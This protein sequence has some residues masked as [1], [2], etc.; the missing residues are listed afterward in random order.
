MH[1]AVYR[2]TQEAL[3]NVVRHAKAQSAWVQLCVG[4][5]HVHLVI[6][7]DGQGFDT[8]SV[9]RGGRFGLASMRDRATGTGGELLVRSAAGEGSVVTAAWAAPVEPVAQPEVGPA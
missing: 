1:E 9:V 4:A 3:N 2:I 5:E 6:E 8:A 7:D